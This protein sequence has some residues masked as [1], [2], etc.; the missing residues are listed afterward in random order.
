MITY[1]R[2]S[3]IPRNEKNNIKQGHCK[4]EKK[5]RKNRVQF[6]HFSNEWKMK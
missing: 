2:L 5:E 1:V 3:L 6:K 4:I